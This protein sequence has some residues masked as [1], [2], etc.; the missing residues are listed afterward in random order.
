MGYNRYY[1]FRCPRTNNEKR[2]NQDEYDGVTKV[3]APCRSKRSPRNLADSWDNKH[4]E[5]QKSWK[6][7]R[8]K[9]Y[10]G[11]PRGAEHHIFLE[12]WKEM[13]K[14]EEYFRQHDIPYKME[15]VLEKHIYKAPIYSKKVKRLV[16]NYVYKWVYKDKKLVREAQHQIGYTE[17]YEFVI[18][19]YQTKIGATLTGYN[20]VWWSDKDI[21]IDFILKQRGV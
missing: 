10:R 14:M 19:G 2:A 11:E 16:P 13:C 18:I 9:Q 7:R 20:L 17:E 6:V 12:G 15:R 3:K 5:Y 1:I 21:G 4:H 8:Q